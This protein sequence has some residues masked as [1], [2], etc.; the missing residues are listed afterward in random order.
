VADGET[1]F[2]FDAYTPGGLAMAVEE[3]VDTYRTPARW[4]WMVEHAVERDFGWE[5][6][7]AAYAAVYRRVLSAAAVG[8]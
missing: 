4:A 8:R 3:A 7:A 1:G 5:R 6:S 2:L